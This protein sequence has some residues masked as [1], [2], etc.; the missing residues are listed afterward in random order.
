MTVSMIKYLQKVIDKFTETLRGTKASPAR[1]TLFEIREEED[2]KLLPEK[3]A[4]QFRR[5]IA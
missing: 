5:T 2:I 3:Q 4:S 1:E